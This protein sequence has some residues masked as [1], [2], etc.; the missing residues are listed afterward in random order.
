MKRGAK[1]VNIY[2]ESGS[3]RTFTNNN[4]RYIDLQRKKAERR[5]T[6]SKFL[7]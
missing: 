2:N 7:K 3:D 5:R 4:V 1:N 6:F